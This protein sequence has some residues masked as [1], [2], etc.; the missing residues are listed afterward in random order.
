MRNIRVDGS[1]YIW[2]A[3]GL[4]VL[5]LSWQM[6][7]ILAAFVHE[8]CHYL[9]ARIWKVRIRGIRIGIGGM[10]MYTEPMPA[11]KEFVVAMA[12][13]AGS[14]L[15]GLWMR[16][17]PELALCGMIQGA[18]NLIPVFPLDGGR[19]LRCL[20]GKW[21]EPIETGVLIVVFI[22]GAIMGIRYG[23]FPF[24]LAVLVTGK[25]IRRK[26]PCKPSKQAVQ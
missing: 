9:A 17:F 16:Q 14:L 20:M 15:L 3:L 10:L 26:F 24:L 11:E 19:M 8:M 13:P 18:Y 5:P 22:F 1:V 2:L 4:F 7:A 6:A 21:S 23:I 12:G 25:T